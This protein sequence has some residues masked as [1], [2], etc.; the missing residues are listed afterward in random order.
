MSIYSKVKHVVTV[1][2]YQGVFMWP[3]NRFPATVLLGNNLE[4]FDPVRTD[5]RCFI[6]WIPDESQVRVYTSRADY[7]YL[8]LHRIQMTLREIVVRSLPATRIYMIEPIHPTAVLRE[9]KLV[10]RKAAI[11]GTPVEDA[12]VVPRLTGSAPSKDELD[13]WLPLQPRFPANNRKCFDKCVKTTLDRMRHFRGHLRMRVHFGGMSLRAY[14]RPGDENH[15]LDEFFDM[16]R[17]PQTVGEVAR[18]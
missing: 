5:N 3:R 8:A 11:K 9:V 17:N 10:S 14:K 6:M 12:S 15:S 1:A 2:L 7:M 4:A 13:S 18:E 16:L